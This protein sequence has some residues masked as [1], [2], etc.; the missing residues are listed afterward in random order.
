[1]YNLLLTAKV[2]LDYNFGLMLW[3]SVARRCYTATCLLYPILYLCVLRWDP[4]LNHASSPTIT[5]PRQLL[6]TFLPN[7]VTA[8]VLQTALLDIT[9]AFRLKY[10][11][12]RSLSFMLEPAT[13][14]LVG[15]PYVSF[16]NP[17]GMTSWL[18]L[19][20]HVDRHFETEKLAGVEVAFL[21]MLAAMVVL[22]C[23]ATV[24]VK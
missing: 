16:R 18:Q 2:P 21:V 6:H 5:V 24:L 9:L 8:F 11:A 15:I 4:T 14:L 20:E 10:N 12:T 7:L 17:A 1:M 19:S 23:G 3:D 22:A 13:A